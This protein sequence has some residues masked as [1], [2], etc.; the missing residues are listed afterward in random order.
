MKLNNSNNLFSVPKIVLPLS[1][2][3]ALRLYDVSRSKAVI[4]L[5]GAVEPCGKYKSVLNRLVGLSQDSVE[6]PSGF[7]LTQHDNSQIVPKTFDLKSYQKQQTT[8]I[9]ANAF[10]SV[11]SDNLYQYKEES[12]PGHSIYRDLTKPER[13]RLV[14][15]VTEYKPIFR[16]ERKHLTSTSHEPM[17]ELYKA[18]QQE[19]SGMK[20]CSQC[21]VFTKRTDIRRC[22]DCDVGNFQPISAE[23]IHEEF[24]NRAKIHELNYDC[25]YD[26]SSGYK[27]VKE[28]LSKP[29]HRIIPADPDMLPPTTKTN[30]ANLVNTAGHR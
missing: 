20:V 25:R 6:V 15:I 12:Y 13:D 26:P 4:D 10:I 28:T 5:K 8:I 7:F 14:D 27:V 19:L 11:D 23:E 16:S 9:N 2:S 21:S 18:T 24:K 1:V 3:E 29:K 17:V 30:L 22:V